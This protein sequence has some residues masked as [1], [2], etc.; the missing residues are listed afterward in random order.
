MLSITFPDHLSI[1]ITLSVL[2]WAIAEVRLWL[3]RKR[4]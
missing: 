3:S 2:I 1:G 4:P